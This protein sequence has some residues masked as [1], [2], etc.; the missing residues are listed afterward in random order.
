MVTITAVL[1]TSFKHVLLTLAYTSIFDMCIYMHSHTNRHIPI[2]CHWKA[3]GL[4]FGECIWKILY[5]HLDLNG[6][7]TGAGN[8]GLIMYP[9]FKIQIFVQDFPYELSEKVTGCLAVARNSHIHILSHNLAPWAD[10][11]VP[12]RAPH[13]V[14]GKIIPPRR[15]VGN[16][17]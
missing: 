3:P 2:F 11:P 9:S 6:G 5:K 7:G 16:N 13:T 4:F 14:D 12:C 1:I 15:V 17:S 10:E 8:G